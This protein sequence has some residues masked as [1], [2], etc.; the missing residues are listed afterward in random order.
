MSRAVI[1]E[2]GLRIEAEE[3]HPTVFDMHSLS[4]STLPE[5][6]FAEVVIACLPTEANIEAAYRLLQPEG[7]LRVPRCPPGAIDIDIKIAGFL[8]LSRSADSELMCRK[9]HWRSGEKAA[10]PGLASAGRVQLRA[11]VELAAD[12]LIDEDD[13]LA[14]TAAAIPAASSGCGTRTSGGKK[15]ACKDC[16]CG[17]PVIYLLRVADLKPPVGLAKEERRE[18]GGSKVTLTLE[19][20]VARASSCGGCYRG[21]AF[22][23]GSCPLLGMP[24]FEPGQERVMLSLSAD[25]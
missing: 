18:S 22:R 11:A 4:L 17:R 13:L 23:C 5:G 10:I 2:G 25:I 21:D 20:K 16:T 7:V 19:E 12:D 8:D 1:V 24:A 14:D 6:V 3:A 9:P 15:R